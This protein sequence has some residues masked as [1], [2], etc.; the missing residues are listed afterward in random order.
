VIY[1]NFC[2]IPENA[3]EEEFIEHEIKFLIDV[4]IHKQHEI[5][6]KDTYIKIVKN[7][8]IDWLNKDSKMNEV[9]Q[10]IVIRKDLKMRKGK[11]IAQGA[12]AAMKV[13]LDKTIKTEDSTSQYLKLNLLKNDPMFK[14]LNGSFTK[15]VVG[16]DSLGELEKIESKAMELGIMCAKII[17]EG[18]TEFK[19]KKTIT[20]LAVGPEWSEKLDPIT[21]NLKLI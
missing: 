13:I 5:K 8:F 11:A 21:S 6:D 15:I 1:K 18:R 9:K 2:I 3:I 14:W 17:D 7:R 10:V 19:N 4:S 12:H 20:A 16:V